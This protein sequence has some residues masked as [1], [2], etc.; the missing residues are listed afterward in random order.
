MT[1]AI[2]WT[3]SRARSRR[4]GEGPEQE[5]ILDAAIACQSGGHRADWHQEEPNGWPMLSSGKSFEGWFQL[6]W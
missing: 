2:Y 1:R 3:S 4:E 6:R 5:T